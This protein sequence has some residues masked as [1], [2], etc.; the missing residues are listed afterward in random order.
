M[1]GWTVGICFDITR[2]NNYT[3]LPKKKISWF[4]FIMSLV[5]ENLILII[6][7]EKKTRN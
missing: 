5:I 6:N 7:G 3:K 1:T 2:N 4:V